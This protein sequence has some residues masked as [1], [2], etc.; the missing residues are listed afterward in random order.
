MAEEKIYHGRGLSA[1]I[2]FGPASILPDFTYEMDEV[3]IHP[4]A[5]E[6]VL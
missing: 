5:V 6:K 3:E 4:D 2:G 1:G